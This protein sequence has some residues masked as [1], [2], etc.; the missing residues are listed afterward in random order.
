M[1]CVYDFNGHD[2]TVDRTYSMPPQPFV[3]SSV[4][5]LILGSGDADVSFRDEHSIVT[6]SQCGKE[7]KPGFESNCAYHL[8]NR[9]DVCVPNYLSKSHRKRKL[10]FLRKNSQNSTNMT[11]T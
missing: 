3:P 7:G 6:Y 5:P 11:D 4:C 1:L 10:I 9:F 8:E 2:A